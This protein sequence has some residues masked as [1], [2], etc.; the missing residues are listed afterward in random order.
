MAKTANF[1]GRNVCDMIKRTEVGD[2]EKT[3]FN[4]MMV[5]A[6]NFFLNFLWYGFFIVRQNI[7]LATNSIMHCGLHSKG[8]RHKLCVTLSVGIT[9]V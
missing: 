4:D 5:V 1:E 8:M 7:D 2:L 3:N 9:H 6:V